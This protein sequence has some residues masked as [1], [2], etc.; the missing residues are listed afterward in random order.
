MPASTPI[1]RTYTLH[2]CLPIYMYTHNKPPGLMQTKTAS[3]GKSRH[4]H[5][6]NGFVRED[7]LQRRPPEWLQT[8]NICQLQI[9]FM[10]PIN[11]GVALALR[12]FLTDTVLHECCHELALWRKAI[13]LKLDQG[14]S[15]LDQAQDDH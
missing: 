4:P 15:Q 1:L 3:P 8:A 6:L 10:H 14:S 12:L 7:I 13:H 2:L 11:L 5:R 9:S